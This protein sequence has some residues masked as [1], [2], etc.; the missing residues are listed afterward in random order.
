M[1][2]SRDFEWK[3]LCDQKLSNSKT[4]F[5]PFVSKPDANLSRDRLDPFKD[6]NLPVREILPAS[7][8][9]TKSGRKEITI[10]MIFIFSHDVICDLPM[11]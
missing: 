1:G 6:S 5:N 9:S 11:S 4:A 7:E 2:G 10:H 8:W 3:D